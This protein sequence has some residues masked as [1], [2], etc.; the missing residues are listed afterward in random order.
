MVAA[1]VVDVGAVA[2]AVAVLDADAA[3]PVGLAVPAA[4]HVAPAA[5]A[6]LVV[7]T[8]VVTRA[9]AGAA[10]PVAIVAREAISSRT[11]SRS[12]AWPRW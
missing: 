3:G 7:A 6:D 8:A 5:V 2:R 12:I 4:V 10:T 11:W 1:V 9:V